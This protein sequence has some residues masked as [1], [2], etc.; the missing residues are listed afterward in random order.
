MLFRSSHNGIPTFQQL[1]VHGFENLTSNTAM[2]V[3]A[4]MPKD[5][6]LEIHGYLREVNRNKKIKD[7]YAR[8]YS[9][10]ADMDYEQTRQWYVQQ[11]VFWTIQARKVK[12]F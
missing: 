6:V 12:P 2:Y 1:G 8:E 5:K 9:N 3:S 4:K 11:E 7:F 10:P